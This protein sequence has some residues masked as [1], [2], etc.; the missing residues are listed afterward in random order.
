ML[1]VFREKKFFPACR[2][3]RFNQILLGITIISS[4]AKDRIDKSLALIKLFNN[5]QYFH[6]VDLK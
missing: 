1:R 2:I 3:G 6:K 4:L 5:S